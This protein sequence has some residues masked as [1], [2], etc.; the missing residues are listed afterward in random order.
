MTKSSK[1][2]L[3]DRNPKSWTKSKGLNKLKDLK[4]IIWKKNQFTTIRS[5][6]PNPF[7]I[8][9]NSTS[10]IIL[11]FRWLF[12]HFGILYS[13]ISPSKILSSLK[14]GHTMFL[15]LRKC[16]VIKFVFSYFFVCLVSTLNNESRFWSNLVCKTKICSHSLL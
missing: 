9:R 2:C 4:I 5:I 1:N 14:S 16:C 10:Y 12:H 8:Q 3:D 15:F 7:G 6:N 11:P 13:M